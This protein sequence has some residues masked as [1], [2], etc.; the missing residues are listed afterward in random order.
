MKFSCLIV[1]DEPLAVA[2]MENHVRQVPFLILAGKCFNAMEAIAFLEKNEVDLIFL[3]IEMPYLTGMQL[4]S[5]LPEKQKVI[6]TTAY[7]EF[8]IESYEKNAFDYLLKP[9]TF[10]RFLKSVKRLQGSESVKPVMSNSTDAHIFVKS[11]REIIKLEYDDILF[12][13]GLKDYVSLVTETDK[14]IT[15]KLMRELEESLPANF[16]RVHLSYIINCNKIR[17]ISDNQVI[18]QEK[19]IPISEKY[20]ERFLQKV[21]DR[22]L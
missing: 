11:G 16:A 17:K 19:S 6:F 21:S 20:R 2:L 3:D 4:K 12:I 10:E 14:V 9:I 7:S 18:I 13:E 15:Y 8:A 1:D 22:M 5:F